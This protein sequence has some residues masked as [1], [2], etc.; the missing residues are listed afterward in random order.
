MKELPP[1]IKGETFLAGFHSHSQLGYDEDPI[2]FD[3]TSDKRRPIFFSVSVMPWG[4]TIIECWAADPRIR[5]QSASSSHAVIS[6]GTRKGRFRYFVLVLVFL[7]HFCFFFSL[8]SFFPLFLFCYF[9]TFFI[10]SLSFFPSFILHLSTFLYLSSPI[11]SSPPFITSSLSF[12]YH[13]SSSC[14]TICPILSASF[15]HIF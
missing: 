2:F 12:F 8:F 7:L 14:L 15:I 6:Q 9:T 4:E 5:L 1:S 10:F 11:L 3:A 13:A